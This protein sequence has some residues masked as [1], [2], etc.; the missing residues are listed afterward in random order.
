M[1]NSRGWLIIIKIVMEKVMTIKYAVYNLNSNDYDYFDT[2]EQAVIEFWDRLID[3]AL[4]HNNNT[5]YMTVETTS[6]G[7][8]VWK[9]ESGDVLEKIL[10]YSEIVE[11]LES[12]KKSEKILFKYRVGLIDIDQAWIQLIYSSNKTSEEVVI[13]LALATISGQNLDD[14]ARM[15]APT[16]TLLRISNCEITATSQLSPSFAEF[17]P[18]PAPPLA[19]PLTA[20]PVPI[21]PSILDNT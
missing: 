14:V 2:K 18:P 1:G 19:P 6:D 4:L 8:E 12:A 16:E 20:L 9:N 17:P 5:P 3:R 13:T 21:G 11:K 10:S 15:Y 7:S